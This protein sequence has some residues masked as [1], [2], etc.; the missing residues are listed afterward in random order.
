MRIGVDRDV[1][2]GLQCPA[3]SRVRQVEAPRVGIEFE[4]RIALA[5]GGEHGVEVGLEA[6]SAGDLAPGR[7]AEHV[8]VRVPDRAQQSAGGLIALLVERG[9]RRRHH[10]IELIEH[11]VGIVE[12]A[13]GQDVDFGSRQQPNVLGLSVELPDSLDVREQGVDLESAGESRTAGVVG[14]GKSLEAAAARDPDELFEGVPSVRRGAVHVQVTSN[15][16]LF[17][18]R[19]EDL[20]QTF[21]A[22]HRR[23]ESFFAQLRWNPCQVHRRIDVLLGLPGDIAWR[24]GIAKIGLF[25]VTSRIVLCFPTFGRLLRL[26]TKHTVLIDTQATILS[27]AAQHHIVIFRPG[28]ILQG[29]SKRLGRHD[30]KIDLQ[31]SAKSDRHLGIAAANDGG[32]FFETPELVHNGV[33]VGRIDEQVQVADRFATA[34]ITSGH[35][36]LPDSFELPHVNEQLLHDLVGVSPIQTC[37]SGGSR[38]DARE[39]FLLGFSSEPF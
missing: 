22:D 20:A 11:L 3:H 23:I 34:A 14:D 12:S 35:L 4:R 25:G 37:V 5:R 38:I 9:V 27:H 8:H 32:H 15:V 2:A 10:N 33:R 28:E 29:S 19:V 18:Q 24:L 1:A 31:P 7:V 17:D 30:A 26:D 39:D 13:V 21:E 16:V 36:K 6:A